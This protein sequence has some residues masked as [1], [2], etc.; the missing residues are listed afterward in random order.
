MTLVKR[1]DWRRMSNQSKRCICMWI[2]YKSL[3]MERDSQGHCSPTIYSRTWS[4]RSRG[5]KWTR[6]ETKNWPKS[7]C[8][9]SFLLRKL[10][11]VRRK[12]VG[13]KYTMSCFKSIE[14]ISKEASVTWSRTQSR[15]P[16]YQNS[17]HMFLGNSAFSNK[18]FR[19]LFWRKQAFSILSYYRWQS[20][21]RPHD[22]KALWSI[23]ASR[24]SVT[25]TL[26]V[27]DPL[28]FKMPRF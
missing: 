26:W 9:K 17:D 23:G 10:L 20:R 27:C 16:C 1:S 28:S 22:K 8:W 6:I 2:R 12:Q 5:Q 21:I 15:I 3:E 24:I 13:E 25:I 19:R 14:A 4:S 18:N 11:H 7:C